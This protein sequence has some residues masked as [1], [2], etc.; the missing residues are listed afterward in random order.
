MNPKII[1]EIKALEGKEGSFEGWLEWDN[2]YMQKNIDNVILPKIIF[3]HCPMLKENMSEVNIVN[4]L[5][6]SHH[7]EDILFYS[8]H[9]D[10][11]PRQ[12]GVDIDGT[13][14]IFDKQNNYG[15]LVYLK[16]V[17]IE[18]TDYI[19]MDIDWEIWKVEE[20]KNK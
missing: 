6:S 2:D 15:L 10:C 7:E 19:C 4:E 9:D 16:I 18:M 14:G 12:E 5:V 3:P 11:E 20:I 8:R 1:A 13:L 17:G